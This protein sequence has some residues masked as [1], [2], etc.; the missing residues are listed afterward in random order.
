MY[1]KDWM[2]KDPIVVSSDTPIIEAQKI[3][4]DSKI[5]R[6][7]VVDKGKLVGIVTYR[8]LIEASPSDATTLS[9]HELNYLI[10]KLKVKDIMKKKVITVSPDDTAEYASLL[11]NKH[12][13]GGL[14][15]LDKRGK[16]VGIVTETDIYRAYNAILGANEDLLRITIRDVDVQHG[17]ITNISKI[18][19]EAGGT[20][21]SIFSI[22]QRAS[23]LRMVVL[24]IRTE[25]HKAVVEAL[26]AKGYAVEK[27]Q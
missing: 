17:T 23:D 2:T 22:P 20:V 12:G 6:L 4:R 1:V 19:D 27:A 26:K 11:G 15:V 18:V 13:V 8:D 5:R 24:R 21:V 7:P 14:P 16:L 10:S 3:M 9:V 25:K